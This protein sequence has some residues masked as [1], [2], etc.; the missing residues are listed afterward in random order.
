MVAVREQS[1]PKNEL[2]GLVTVRVVQTPKTNRCVRFRGWWLSGNVQGV[3]SR[4]VEE[5][6]GRTLPSLIPGYPNDV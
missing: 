4:L 6:L 1:K 5:K 2:S 3:S